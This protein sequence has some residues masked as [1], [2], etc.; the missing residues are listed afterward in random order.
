MESIHES[1]LSSTGPA[2]QDQAAPIGASAGSAGGPP[3]S[4]AQGGGPESIPR[5]FSWRVLGASALVLIA[6][7]YGLLKFQ[8]K[9][10]TGYFRGMIAGL[11]G[12]FMVLAGPLVA[13]ATYFATTFFGEIL[14]PGIPLSVNRL[15]GMGV[16]AAWG[17]W[18]LAGRTSW[19][20]GAYLWVLVTA[21]VYYVLNAVLGQDLE[22]GLAFAR[23]IA[24]Y[25]LLGFVL[26]TSLRRP[27]HWIFWFWLVILITAM[28]SAVG[29]AEFLTGL[30]M[31]FGGAWQTRPLLPPRINGLSQ[32]AIMFAYNSLWAFPAGLYLFLHSRWPWQRNVAGMI[33]LF[34]V[35]MALLTLNRQ[36][37]LVLFAMLVTGALV[38]R[39]RIVRPLTVGLIVIGLL[40]SPYIVQKMGERVTRAGEAVKDPSY[41]LRRDKFRIM[42][43]MVARHPVFGV[44]LGS[45]PVVWP[46]YM[47]ENLWFLQLQR[48]SLQYPDLG[49]MQMMAESGIVGFALDLAILGAGAVLLL[50]RR[51]R[52]LQAGNFAV[53]N[54]CGIL[55]ILVVHVT[56]KQLIQD[57]FF[58]QRSWW[59]YAM[60]VVVSRYP[61]ERL[62]ET[63]RGSPEMP[64]PHEPPT[65]AR[66]T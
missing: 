35:A 23:Y 49:Y 47:P 41:A 54:L 55:L 4:T 61:D 52:A 60:I 64:A 62:A 9:M 46:E 2:R 39:H 7:A 19:P 59:L 65:P 28:S 42:K 38:L 26:L 16:L 14:L 20:G 43:E 11:L 33:T 45:F 5:P 53:V 6:A 51:R 63:S 17:L 30:D 12:I 25:E 29:L 57:V 13:L 24:L 27:P 50:K 66:T 21:S 3:P 48:P 8:Q 58:F 22:A 40:A 31:S 32:N 44:G 56:I 37:P 18:I 15:V 34:I 36:T 10:G 1:S